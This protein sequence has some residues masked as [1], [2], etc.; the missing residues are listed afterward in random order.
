MGGVL[1][2]KRPSTA[3]ATNTYTVTATQLS[4]KVGYGSLSL[5]PFKIIKAGLENPIS[6]PIGGAGA[7]VTKNITTTITKGG[8]SSLLKLIGV[9]GA[10][11]VGGLLLGGGK[12]ETTQTP[13]QTP[14]Q[15]GGAQTVTPIITP[16]V[17]PNQVTTTTTETSNPITEIVN[18]Y[19]TASG[20]Y[21]S[22]Y[23]GSVSPK[24]ESV[25]KTGVE[26]SQTTTT[27]TVFEIPYT[28]GQTS[29]QPTTSEQKT[30]N[31][32]LLLIAGVILAGIL[33]FKKK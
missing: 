33:L 2:L 13:T 28:M 18:Y 24:A 3:P 12:Q 9:G 11:L 4:Q 27:P 6:S 31:S 30:D 5:D 25:V 16:I 15:T 8:T 22:I 10:G 14:T 26:P 19:L 1:L 32:M 23:G 7:V 29:T 21:S 20:Q 17:T